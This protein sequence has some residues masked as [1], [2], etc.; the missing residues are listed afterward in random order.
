MAP[1]TKNGG[2]IVACH[3]GTI[4]TAKS[5]DTTVCTDSTSGV[6][7]PPR[8]RYT[9]SYRRQWI[10]EP[11]QP[12]ARMPYTSRC[13]FFWAWSRRAAR[14]GTRPKYQNTSDTVKYVVTANTSHVSGL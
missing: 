11:R 12:R 9:F 4:D 8:S 2:K 3:S 14:S 5:K 13:H 6:L 7:R 1:A 10:A